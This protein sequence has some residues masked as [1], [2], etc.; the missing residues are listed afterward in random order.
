MSVAIHNSVSNASDKFF[1]EL[2][3]KNYTTPTSYLDLIKTYIEML[4]YQ[5]G[6]VP[7]KIARYQGGLKRLGDTNVMVDAMKAELIILAPQIDQKTEETE[8]LMVVLAAKKVIADEAAKMTAIE[9]D[10]A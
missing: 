1:N 9:S 7:V 4:K 3:R 5:R 6:I 10:A 2:R 8:K